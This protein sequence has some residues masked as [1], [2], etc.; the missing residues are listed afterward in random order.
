MVVKIRVVN[1]LSF[2]FGLLFNMVYKQCLEHTILQNIGA[3]SFLVP[4]L[5][6][7]KI[8]QYSFTQL[9]VCFSA[10]EYLLFVYIDLFV[11]QLVGWPVCWRMGCPRTVKSSPEVCFQ[12]YAKKTSASINCYWV[13]IPHPIWIFVHIVCMRWVEFRKLT[14]LVLPSFKE[15]PAEDK[16]LYIIGALQKSST[17][18]SLNLCGFTSLKTNL[19]FDY[20][21]KAQKRSLCLARLTYT[22]VKTFVSY[23]M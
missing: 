13:K 11:C 9:K 7:L 2:Q 23:G 6:I 20:L 1:M 5:S 14:N 18:W 12:K 19:G 21:Y 16:S 10:Y 15:N 4:M 8:E 3:D 17:N 22:A